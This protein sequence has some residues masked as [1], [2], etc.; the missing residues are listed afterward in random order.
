MAAILKFPTKRCTKKMEIVFSVI[1]CQHKWGKIVYNLDEKS[2]DVYLL[3]NCIYYIH[4]IVILTSSS[5]HNNSCIGF[6]ILQNIYNISDF[7]FLYQLLPAKDIAIIRLLVTGG[8]H[9]EFSHEKVDDKMETVLFQFFRVNI[10]EN[11]II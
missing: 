8:G 2:Q 7:K 9:L 6:T 11:T 3:H 5:H 10:S 4:F 1:Y